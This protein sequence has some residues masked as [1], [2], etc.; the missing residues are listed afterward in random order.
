MG[1]N[2]RFNKDN[3]AEK[4]QVTIRD[5]FKLNKKEI[6]KVWIAYVHEIAKGTKHP[7]IILKLKACKDIDP[8][9]LDYFSALGLT[10]ITKDYT[11][12][13]EVAS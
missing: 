1:A 12:V 10:I 11:R 13:M 5:E 6:Y 4:I 7:D 8:I 2:R 9:A 3:K